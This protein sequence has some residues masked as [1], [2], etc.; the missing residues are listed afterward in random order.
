M[1]SRMDFRIP[2]DIRDPALHPARN[3]GT[4]TRSRITAL[5]PAWKSGSRAISRIT[6][7]VPH[8]SPLPEREPG[9]RIESRMVVL[10]PCESPAPALNPAWNYEPC[11]R[12]APEPPRIASHMDVRAPPDIHGP[13]SKPTYKSRARTRAQD[14]ALKPARTCAN[15]Y[16]IPNPTWNA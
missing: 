10:I 9:S 16:E 6:H 4:S 1:V 8:C 5:S 13:A 12:E 14:P 2:H 3:A 7:C 11:A 15:T